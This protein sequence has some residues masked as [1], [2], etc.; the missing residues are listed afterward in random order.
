MKK[1]GRNDPCPCNSG[2]KF[3]KCHLKMSYNLDKMLDYNKL[4]Q[5]MSLKEPQKIEA[6]FAGKKFRAI[7]NKLH[8]SKITETDDEFCF[9]YLSGILGKEWFKEELEK[10]H[11]HIVFEWFE[12]LKKD[13]DESKTKIKHS[14]NNYS[15]RPCGTTQSLRALA[16]DVYF[17]KKIS[18][19]PEI[20]VKRLKNKKEFQGVRHEIAIASILA[21]TGNFKIKFN[22]DNSSGQPEFDA[23]YTPSG[24]KII[25]EAKSRRRKGA[26]NEKGD[27]ISKEDFLDIDNLLRQALKRNAQGQPYIVFIDLNIPPT[28][29]DG[30]SGRYWIPRIN[31]KLNHIDKNQ[32]GPVNYNLLVISNFSWYY[33]GK[34]IAHS[35][36]YLAVTPPLDRGPQKYVHRDIIPE[37]VE[38]LQRY[39]DSLK[40]E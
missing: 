30:S 33:L 10:K 7:G 28:S 9:R 37:I 16:L 29:K 11:P 40:S 24:D 38:S 4:V 32:R 6:N 25:V 31:D 34:E 17:L 39:G 27:F 2:K 13:L 35:G 20:I 23:T 3:K 26:Y 5:G 36:N 1:V 18:A 14:N 15:I 12:A 8:I 21:R 22:E 19:L